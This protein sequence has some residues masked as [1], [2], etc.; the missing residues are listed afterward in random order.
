MAHMSRREYRMK[1]EHGQ[2]QAEKA[3][4]SYAKNR[5]NSREEFQLREK[6]HEHRNKPAITAGNSRED[7]THVKLNFWQIFSDR[8]YVSVFL[9]LVAIFLIMI[10]LWWGLAILAVLIALGIV[11]IGHSH[12]PHQVLSLEFKM[13]ASRKLSMLRALQLGGS[14]LMFLATYMKQVVNVNFSSAG[15][16]DSLQVVEGMLSSRGGSYGQQ[17]TY[18]LN[19]LNTFTGNQLWSTYRYATNSA[20]MMSS[21]SGRWIVMWTLLLMIAP[22]FCV[23]AQFFKEPYSRNATLIASIITMVSFLFTPILMKRWVVAYA[24]E[25]QMDQVSAQSAVTIGPMAYVAIACAIGVMIIAFYRFIK[26]DNFN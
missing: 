17:G 15:S 26:R 12:H 6:R 18:F 25:N 16:T 23:L 11:V 22:A 24:V 14:V 9:I 4:S 13:K 20:Q 5:A 21:P 10:K 2:M 7:Y 19:L 1:K 3:R 8:P